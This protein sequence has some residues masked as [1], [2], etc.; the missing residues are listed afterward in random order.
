MAKSTTDP[1]EL[2]DEIINVL[3]A[4][5]DTTASLLSNAFFL[6]A[7]HPITWNRVRA[8]VEETFADK[9]PDYTTLRSMKQVKN[10]LNECKCSQSSWLSTSRKLTPSIG[11]RLFPPVPFNSRTAT[12]NTTL[13]R[14][15][16]GDENAP[17]FI[18]G[19]QQVNYHV[20]SLHRLT[21]TFGPDADDFRPDR[22]DDASLRPGWGFIP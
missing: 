21:E 10:L 19:G 6:L 9:L 13:P 18:K 22:W 7:R 11:L 3:T 1:R 20:Y 16:G 14:G 15:G 2:R 17:I 4:G 5:G 12:A 8:E